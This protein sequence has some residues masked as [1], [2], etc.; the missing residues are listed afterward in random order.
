MVRPGRLFAASALLALVGTPAAAAQP[1]ALTGP[2]SQNFDTLSNTGDT[3]SYGAAGSTERALGGLRSGTLIPI[4]GA[5]FTNN[6]GTT[7]ASLAVSYT[8]EEWR[9]GTAA[10]TD[11][12][13][14][15]YSL[16]ATDLTTG[17]WTGV[18]ALTFVTPD[19]VTT[20]ALTAKRTRRGVVVGW[21]TADES[22]IA[23][24]ELYRERSGR[25][26]KLNRTLIRGLQAGSFAGRS[27][28]WLDAQAAPNAL[29][30]LQLV[31]LDGTRAWYG[32]VR[33]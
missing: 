21:R 31:R 24:F 32:T 10:R 13:N 4:F 18:A 3:Y 14:F 7:I 12:L 29:Y 16:N 17:T 1:V 5:S 27:Y 8:G 26:V 33:A 30:R 22:R 23:G 20:G 11:Q 6:T 15:E 2:Y 9:L 19:T 25:P 28:A